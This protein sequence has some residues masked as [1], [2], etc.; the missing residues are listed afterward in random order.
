MPVTHFTYTIVPLFLNFNY[1]EDGRLLIQ[2]VST[3]VHEISVAS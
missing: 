3:R 1:V 2:C